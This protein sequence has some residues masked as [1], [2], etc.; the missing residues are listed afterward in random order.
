MNPLIMRFLHCKWN[1]VKSQNWNKCH[2]VPLHF[3][4]HPWHLLCYYSL[5]VASLLRQDNSIW[6]KY[7][8]MKR[9]LKT[10]CLKSLHRE[11]SLRQKCWQYHYTLI[12]LD[13]LLHQHILLQ[14]WS[15]RTLT[16]HKAQC[17]KHWLRSR[18]SLNVYNLSCFQKWSGAHVKP[19]VQCTV[20]FV[21]YLYIYRSLL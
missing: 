9:K 4:Q 1:V 11:I 17:S 18:L 7:I 20:L 2:Q 6:C 8:H 14:W 12:L 5:M 3:V 21:S 13:V 15:H 16:P 10:L 19:L